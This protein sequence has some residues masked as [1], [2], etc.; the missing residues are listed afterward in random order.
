MVS[1][2]DGFPSHNYCHDK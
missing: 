1:V 2:V